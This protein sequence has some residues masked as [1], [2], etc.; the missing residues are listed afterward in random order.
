[1]SITERM[2]KCPARKEEEDHSNDVPI[3]F[4]LPIP[5]VINIITYPRALQ[6][7]SQYSSDGINQYFKFIHCAA[8]DQKSLHT[9]LR[10]E[11]H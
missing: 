3:S 2:T 10:S 11:L 4:R 7:L 9:K 6:F 8:K 5:K 1:M